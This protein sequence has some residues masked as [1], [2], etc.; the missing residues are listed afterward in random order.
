MGSIWTHITCTATRKLQREA[1]N[2]LETRYAERTENAQ[3]DQSAGD[4]DSNSI[5]GT[6]ALIK[7][8]IVLSYL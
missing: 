7:A 2:K 6:G 3:W 5:N 8:L 1:I 4:W